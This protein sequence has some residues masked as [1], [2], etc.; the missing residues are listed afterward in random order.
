MKHLKLSLVAIVVAACS[1]TAS[2]FDLSQLGSALGN[3]GLGN[4]INSVISSD[5]ITVADVTGEWTYTSPAVSF[6]S[7]DLLKK[8]G[9]A[10]VASTV[11]GKLAPF[12]KRAGIDGL[13]M[14][15]DGKGNV[16]ILLKNG[17]TINGTVKQGASAG[18]LIFNL[19]RL[20]S[21]YTNITAYVTKGTD[22]S[23]MFDVSKLQSLVSAIAKYSNNSTAATVSSMLNSYKGIYAGL[24]L[25]K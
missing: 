25:S 11:E 8:A 23:I 1:T 20:G 16:T 6:K 4:V 10:A 15:F 2:A 18:Q 13:K 14:T 19:G 24:K 21:S 7:D 9:G 5:S 12:Y 3:S 17:K 22:L